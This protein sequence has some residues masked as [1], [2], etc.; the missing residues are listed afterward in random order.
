MILSNVNIAV[1]VLN[2]VHDGL[3]TAVLRNQTTLGQPHTDGTTVE[4]N[5]KKNIG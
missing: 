4:L 3:V 2:I 5:G 1:V